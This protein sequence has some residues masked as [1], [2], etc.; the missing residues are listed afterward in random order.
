MGRD[1]SRLWTVMGLCL[2]ASLMLPS[3]AYPQTTLAECQADFAEVLGAFA[4]ETA[5]TGGT[6]GSALCRVV[7]GKAQL[8]ARGTAGGADTGKARDFNAQFDRGQMGQGGCVNTL[9]RQGTTNLM[10]LKLINKG[11]KRSLEQLSQGTGLST[12][13]GLNPL[14]SPPSGSNPHAN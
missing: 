11:V 4:T 7:Q 1:V 2:V 3:S 10:R 8:F 5:V 13:D 9:I 6:R 14:N 12:D